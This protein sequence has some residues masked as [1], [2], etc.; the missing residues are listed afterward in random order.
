MNRKHI[1]WSTSFAFLTVL[2][3]V[4]GGCENAA[5]KQRKA[6]QAQIEADQKKAAADEE[7]M[8]KATQAYNAAQQESMKEQQKVDEQKN[9]AESA[10]SAEKSDYAKQVSS[11]V[12]LLQK[13]VS[14]LHASLN[15]APSTEKANDQLLL[16]DV[17]ARRDTLRGDVASMQTISPKDWPGLKAKID[18]DLEESKT[19][20]RTASA[21]IKKAP[22]SWK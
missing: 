10:F 5:D 2:T 15:A 1:V 16:N 7:A 12:D 18:R 11:Q 6:D 4:A 20:A 3:G 8:R 13:Q 14:D 19:S 21:Q 22:G 17:T 9:E